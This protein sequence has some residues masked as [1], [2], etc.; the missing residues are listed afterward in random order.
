MSGSGLHLALRAP[1]WLGDLAMASPVLAAAASDPRFGKL[2]ILVR[3]HLAPF[4]LD[5]PYERAVVPI[6][7]RADEL[8]LLRSLAPDAVLL[9]P[10]SLGAAWR[11]WRARVPVRAGVALSGRRFLLTHAALPPSR[12]GRRLPAPTVHLHADAAGLLGIEVA[13]R[14]A[15]LHVRA[16]RR[17]AARAEL[18]SMGL[19]RDE[20]F[21]LCSPGAAFG[22]A[23]LWP[24]ER[25]A[26][27]LDALFE[28]RGLRAVVNGGRG[29]EEL[30]D[31]V[32]RA[33]ASGAIS[34]ASRPRELAGL[35]A[36]VA[37]SEL[38]VVGDSGP[39]FVADALGVPYVSV[40]GPTFVELTTPSLAG[41]RALRVEGLECAPCLER[42]CPL[43]HHRCMREL[44]VEPVV[45]AALSL[46][47]GSER[48][49]GST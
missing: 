38:V 44:E 6:E 32:A 27:V 3:A 28:A 2:S 24:A 8:A 42:R 25:F 33:S 23:K 39:R 14:R 46:L 17:D 29:E 21:V 48:V 40:V 30:M 35:K 20:R 16:E 5:E 10:N 49:A 22:A 45:R 18:E 47:D 41:G 1:N 9:L 43:G 34:L 19:A 37:E 12:D 11:A 13:S 31:A 7:R 15:R 4:L 26:A 36:L